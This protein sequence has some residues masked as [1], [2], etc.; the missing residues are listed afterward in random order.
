MSRRKFNAFNEHGFLGRD[1]GHSWL[2]Q[3]VLEAL[4]GAGES[5]GEEIRMRNMVRYIERRLSDPAH[6]SKV[7]QTPLLVTIGLDFPIALRERHRDS[8]LV[9]D[10]PLKQ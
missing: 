4:D 5:D 7:K 1:R 10:S 8:N 2:T 6:S 3:A 9:S